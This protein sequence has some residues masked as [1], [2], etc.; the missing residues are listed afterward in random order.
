M[1]TL[2]RF[3]RPLKLGPDIPLAPLA[4]PSVCSASQQHKVRPFQDTP[5]ISHA[6]LCPSLERTFLP[7]DP[8]VLP[9]A[10]LSSTG[11]YLRPV[12]HMNPLTSWMLFLPSFSSQNTLEAVV[13]GS[14]HHVVLWSTPVLSIAEAI[15]VMIILVPGPSPICSSREHLYQEAPCSFHMSP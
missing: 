9:P 10:R 3:H 7:H 14:K 6:R 1:E 15:P 5:R 12:S 2:R 11:H 8:P 13:T 4:S